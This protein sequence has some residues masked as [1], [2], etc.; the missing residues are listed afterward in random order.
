MAAELCKGLCRNW[1]TRDRLR[2]RRD[3]QSGALPMLSLLLLALAFL[4]DA[5]TQA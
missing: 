2:Y 3:T 1:S 5:L 4:E